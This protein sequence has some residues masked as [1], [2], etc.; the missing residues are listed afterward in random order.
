MGVDPDGK[1]RYI[2]L[3]KNT[4]IAS[5]LITLSLTLLEIPKDYFGSPVGIADIDIGEVTFA[6]IEDKDC[7]N[8]EIVNIDGKRYVVTDTNKKLASISDNETLSE[9]VGIYIGGIFIENVSYLRPFNECQGF[10]KGFYAEIDYYRDSDG[11]I[12]PSTFTYNQ[13]LSHKS[14]ARSEEVVQVQDKRM[15]NIPS[16]IRLKTEFFEGYGVEELI[17][18]I[19]VLGVSSVV[20]YIIYLFTKVTLVSTL[21]VIGSVIVAVVFLTKNRN[22]FSMADNIINIIKY[23]LM[24]K[25]YKYERGNFNKTE[26]TNKNIK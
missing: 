14:E 11:Y 6:K 4:V 1:A 19:I 26:T 25:R 3:A 7:Q 23:E 16:Q 12:F 15:I 9:A 8:R 17:K 2:K 21:F 10:F 18:T 22:N 13:Y 20:A 5:I 24:Q